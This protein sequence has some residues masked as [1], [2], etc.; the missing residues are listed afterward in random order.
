MAIEIQE[1]HELM[2]VLRNFPAQQS[3]F[4]DRYF[5]RSYFSNSE[6]IDFEEVTK[7]K[8]L[9]PFVAPNVQGQ[10]MLAHA[11]S[12]KKF[13]PA[14]VKP[15]DAV[16]PA[17][18]LKRMAGES[19]GGSLTPQEREDAIVADILGDHDE[20]IRRRWEWMACEAVK[21]GM[22]TIS[23]E[24]Y[25]ARTVGFG[26]DP[27]NTVTLSGTARWGQNGSD[28]LRDIENWN[29]VLNKAGTSGRDLLMGP[30][31]AAALLADEKVQ[32]ALETRRGSTT[33]LEK[34]NVAGSPVVYYG[35]LVGG[36]NLFKFTET[37][38]DNEGNE[39]P[40]IEDDELVFVG[41]VDG[42]RAFGAIMDRK[43]GW[44]P[45]AMF[46][47]MW[48]QEDPSALYLMTQSAPLMIPVRVNG[49][50]KANPLG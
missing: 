12:I 14:Y 16:D 41:D 28:P 5:N 2:G 18:T 15:K 29:Q 30:S 3:F 23:G 48:E 31:V 27:A 36:V 40:Y 38:H 6:W 9:A 37:W 1:T 45:Q 21:N 39:V 20:M 17:R 33:T 34:Y 43:A 4:L 11:E 8:R 47:K 26:R 44:A 13:K 24:N 35:S 50:F 22:I 25:P 49:S 42:V 19:L 7:G 46:P 10:P 32:D